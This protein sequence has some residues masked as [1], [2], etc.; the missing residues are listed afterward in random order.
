MFRFHK[1]ESV[2]ALVGRLLAYEV[3]VLFHLVI[4]NFESCNEENLYKTTVLMSCSRKY[5][6]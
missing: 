4:N 6:V 3:E 5:F 2:S 1:C